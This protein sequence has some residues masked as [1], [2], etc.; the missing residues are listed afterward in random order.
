MIE[1]VLLRHKGS[2]DFD[3]YYE[4]LCALESTCPVASVRAGAKTGVLSCPIYRLK[5]QDWHPILTALQINK[6]LHTVAFFDRW[7]TSF[8]QEKRAKGT[9]RVIPK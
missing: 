3:S 2:Q 1:T 6:A 8:L 5:R 4:S 7:E 9:K